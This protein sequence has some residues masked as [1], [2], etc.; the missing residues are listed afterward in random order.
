MSMPAGSVMVT[1]KLL[2]TQ[3][4]GTAVVQSCYAPRIFA[5]LRRAFVLRRVG[6]KR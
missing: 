5:G 4:S 3:A 2:T 6:S 1:V